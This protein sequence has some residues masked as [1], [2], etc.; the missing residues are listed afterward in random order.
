[1]N[2]STTQSVIQTS[3]SAV[4]APYT[5][6]LYKDGGNLEHQQEFVYPF[7]LSAKDDYLYWLF[8]VTLEIQSVFSSDTAQYVAKYLQGG[9][10]DAKEAL[11]DLNR[12]QSKRI[13]D[14]SNRI[15]ESIMKN[16]KDIFLG[17]A[18]AA[19]SSKLESLRIR[20]QNEF[21]FNAGEFVDYLTRWGKRILESVNSGNGTKRQ[22]LWMLTSNGFTNKEHYFMASFVHHGGNHKPTIKDYFEEQGIKD[23]NLADRYNDSVTTNQLYLKNEN[24]P[25]NGP[26]MAPKPTTM[27]YVGKGGMC[28]Y[29]NKPNH[30]EKDCWYKFPE[31]RPPVK[32]PQGNKRKRNHNGNRGP[33]NNRNKRRKPKTNNSAPFPSHIGCVFDV[34]VPGHSP[35]MTNQ[36]GS[37]PFLWDTGS[38]V[39]IVKD[40]DLL[41]DF[42]KS[43]QVFAGIGGMKLVSEGYGKIKGTDANGNA[44]LLDKVYYLKKSKANIISGKR[45]F[46]IENLTFRQQDSTLRDGNNNIINRTDAPGY[47]IVDLKCETFKKPRVYLTE[48]EKQRAYQD[49]HTSVNKVDWNTKATFSQKDL[50]THIRTGHPNHQQYAQLRKE[51]PWLPLIASDIR[52]HCQA[53]QLGTMTNKRKEHESETVV[54]RPLQVI[55]ADVCGP[56]QPFGYDYSQYFLVVVD[57]YTRTYY[58]TPMRMKGDTKLALYNTLSQLRHDFPDGKFDELRIDNGLEFQGPMGRQGHIESLLQLGITPKYTSPY[59]SHQ[60]GTAERAIRALSAKA[61]VLLI[62]SG[63]P[64]TYWP[65]A[66]KMAAHVEEYEDADSQF[67]PVPV[68]KMDISTPAQSS[69]ETSLDLEQA[70]TKTDQILTSSPRKVEEDVSS[71]AGISSSFD[72]DGMDTEEVETQEATSSEPSGAS[73]EPRLGSGEQQ[74]LRT[75]PKNE[76]QHNSRKSSRLAEKRRAKSD[77]CQ[78]TGKT[79]KTKVKYAVTKV[80]YAKGNQSAKSAKGGNRR[81]NHLRRIGQV[82]NAVLDNSVH[83]PFDNTFDSRVL[84]TVDDSLANLPFMNDTHAVNYVNPNKRNKEE[85]K[86]TVHYIPETYKEA[87]SCDDQAKWKEAIKSELESLKSNDTFTE[88]DLP[89]GRRPI[90]YKWIF[91]IKHDG[92]YK[93]RLVA[94]GFSQIKDKDYKETFSPVV[95]YDTVKISLALATKLQM[96]VHQVD[97]KTAFL[98]GRLKS[99][100]YLTIPEGLQTQSNRMKVLKLNGALYGLK[101]APLIWNLEINKKLISIG[102]TPN[103]KEP[104]LYYKNVS[105]IMVIVVLYVD[106]M[107]IMCKDE[108]VIKAVK[109][110][111]K[112]SYDIKDLGKASRFLGMNICQTNSGYSVSLK[113]YIDEKITTYL[114]NDKP[115]YNPCATDWSEKLLPLDDDEL[116]EDPGLYRE[117]IG[118][119]LFA[120]TTVRY[121]IAFITGVLARYCNKP[122]LK[123]FEYCNRVLRYLKSTSEFSLNYTSKDK[124]SRN[125]IKVAGYS[126]ADWGNCKETSKSVSGLIFTMLGA[127]ILWKSKKQG[128]V[129]LSSTE[130]EAYALCE[131]TRNAVWL[132]DFLISLGLWTEKRWIPIYVDNQACLNIASQENFTSERTKHIRIRLSYIQDECKNGNVNLIKIPTEN[133]LSDI[134]TKGLTTDTFNHLKSLG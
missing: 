86:N 78:N 121:D 48:N 13:I 6:H 30:E 115:C 133:N 67:S 11:R 81:V 98:N 84:Y 54:T 61:R 75:D 71:S 39:H 37:S 82:N 20:H 112:R 122:A 2:H 113:E 96:K 72:R 19:A 88:T 108:S 21:K 29:C 14:N 1:M 24:L 89:Y 116:F 104:C 45:P 107:L 46:G 9:E 126:D 80:K 127:P 32:N 7:K 118:K 114:D 90:E 87:I 51:N 60:N 128:P 123:H 52:T 120:S 53:C 50:E 97:V 55:H 23:I 73:T 74:P 43:P 68:D 17:N 44:I 85:E 40:W 5:E 25:W 4:R 134:L 57:K 42:V 33:R 124:S 76:R 34:S 36:F 26:T 110:E 95:K 15:A 35:R 12:D 99:D 47:V 131:T 92:T 16:C 101:Q 65:E 132:K 119:L 58:V 10:N 56:I 3:L 18:Y 69:N 109:A 93:A 79:K 62:Q 41:Y 111:L 63:L 129:A 66:F 49:A 70:S 28:S 22:H 31:Q 91:N 100:L 117:I 106:D 102:F 83:Q 103:R 38:E 77:M 59:N 130:A 8:Q 105:G 125:F 64:L 27:F 94:K